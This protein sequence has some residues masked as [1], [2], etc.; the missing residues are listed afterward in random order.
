MKCCGMESNSNIET[1]NDLVASIINKKIYNNT[2]I[3]SNNNSINIHD[4]NN[5]INDDFTNPNPAPSFIRGTL[6]EKEEQYYLD[7]MAEIMNGEYMPLAIKYQTLNDPYTPPN[8]PC[9]LPDDEEYSG[10]ITEQMPSF[11]TTQERNRISSFAKEHNFNCDVNELAYK[12]IPPV[13]LDTSYKC[14]QIKIQ[15]FVETLGRQ[16]KFIDTDIVKEDI[17]QIFGTELIST[18]VKQYLSY[19]FKIFE[20]LSQE[21]DVLL[22]Y[23]LI[24]YTLINLPIEYSNFDYFEYEIRTLQSDNVKTTITQNDQSFIVVMSINPNALK[25]IIVPAFKQNDITKL[26]NIIQINNKKNSNMQV[27]DSIAN[28]ITSIINDNTFIFNKNNT[29]QLLNNFKIYIKYNSNS[30]NSYL[31]NC[32]EQAIKKNYGILTNTV[33][34]NI[35]QTLLKIITDYINNNNLYSELQNTTDLL[36]TMEIKQSN[37]EDIIKQILTNSN[38][39]QNKNIKVIVDTLNDKSIDK[40]VKQIILSNIVDIIIN[41]INKNQTDSQINIFCSK[42][43]ILLEEDNFYLI[44]DIIKQKMT[45]KKEFTNILTNMTNVINDFLI[46]KMLYY[47]I[48]A[49]ENQNTIEDQLIINARQK[50]IDEV[51]PCIFKI[52][53]NVQNLF[54][55]LNSSKNTKYIQLFING[56]IDFIVKND[57][58]NKQR[59][60]NEEYIQN[61]IL[62]FQV[63][64]N[65]IKKLFKN[66]IKGLLNNNANQM[67]IYDKKRLKDLLNLFRNNKNT[68]LQNIDSQIKTK[69]NNAKTSKIL[70]IINQEGQSIINEINNEKTSKYTNKAKYNNEITD[71]NESEAN[72]ENEIK[73]ESE[74]NHENDMM[75]IEELNIQP[76]NIQP[77]DFIQLIINNN[78]ND[79]NTLVNFINNNKNIQEIKTVANSIID[80][81]IANKVLNEKSIYNNNFVNNFFLKL[82]KEALIVFR[83]LLN[84]RLD[85]GAI[86]TELYKPYHDF[87]VRCYCGVQLMDDDNKD[88]NNKT[89]KTKTK[90]YNKKK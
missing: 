36:L 24:N 44:L 79:A 83:D 68:A 13:K 65:N 82:N 52:K 61:F 76:L 81:V 42:L 46:Y 12:A 72:H 28:S 23:D 8:S 56:I 51:I 31:K 11:F 29:N 58:F 48:D 20:K 5:Y 27:M 4:I 17:E 18:C 19:M 26:K 16:G 87:Y 78:V 55:C 14:K 40:S 59:G 9:G 88:L 7:R 50:F 57:L 1:H 21:E 45:N 75:I 89:I 22:N 33:K 47:D 43:I 71:Y 30:N 38:N 25:K 39:N 69:S 41:N 2:D 54:K 64:K 73:H 53:T 63:L 90:R 70:T 77:N 35:S 84:K 60:I 86:Y 85:D 80:F 34:S 10:F 66:T 67:N 3:M 74:A 32:L 15:E 6:N 49:T 62:K 37:F